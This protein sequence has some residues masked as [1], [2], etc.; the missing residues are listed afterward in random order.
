MGKTVTQVIAE[1]RGGV[2]AN[3]LDEAMSQLVERVQESGKKGKLNITLQLS[4][5]GRANKELHVRVSFTSTLPPPADHADESIW[6]GVRG[7][8][9]RDD[10]DQRELFGPR[11][12]DGADGRS[13]AE[14]AAAIG[15]R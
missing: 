14:H 4:P 10:P 2:I 12:V 9:Q 5:H 6:F 1:H 11:E 8:L 15:A 3:A 7:E 13:P